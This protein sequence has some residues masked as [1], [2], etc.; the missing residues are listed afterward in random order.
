LGVAVSLNPRRRDCRHRLLGS[1]AD[2]VPDA[3]HGPGQDHEE[4]ARD[5]ESGQETRQAAFGHGVGERRLLYQ[6]A[7]ECGLPLGWEVHVFMMVGG[8]MDCSD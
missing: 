8:P 6:V 7:I 2:E 4:Q 3:Q 5:D 1:D